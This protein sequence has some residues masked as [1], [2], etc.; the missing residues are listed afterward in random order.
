[1]VLSRRLGESIAVALFLVD[2]GCLGI[3]SAFWRTMSTA[4]YADLVARFH[5][6]ENLVQARP[7][8]LR[9]LV[10]G[11]LAYAANLGFQPYPDY[12]AAKILFGNLDSGD[13]SREFEFGK[14]GKPFYVSGPNDTPARIQSVM[15]QLTR[16][17]GGPDGFHFIV[18]SPSGFP[19]DFTDPEE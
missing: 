18:G 12:H 9:K 10:E 5:G 14:D 6:R 11:A 2:T 16:R 17:C 3:K 7:E 4:A 8:C 19:D 1:M 15:N 13:C